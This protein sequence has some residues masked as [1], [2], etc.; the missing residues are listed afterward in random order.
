METKRVIEAILFCSKDPVSLEKLMGVLPKETNRSIRHALEELASEYEKE[1]RSFQLMEVA[2]GYQL[3][4]RP[5]YMEMVMKFFRKKRPKLSLPALETVSIIAYKQPV[6]RAEIERI[7]GV[8]VEG[9]LDTLL[10]RNLIRVAGR[11]KKP[12]GPLLYR[13]TREFLKYFDLKSLGDLPRIEPPHE[14]D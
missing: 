1:N 5:E 7:R 3:A 14:G 10:D 9:V 11:A 6:T 12:G 2:G 4:T 8:G 13:T